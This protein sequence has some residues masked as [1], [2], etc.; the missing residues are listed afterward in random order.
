M[1]RRSQR[2]TALSMKPDTK[3]WNFLWNFPLRKNRRTFCE[4]STESSTETEPWNFLWNFHRKFHDLVSV[5]HSVEIPRKVP[6]FGLCGT[7]RGNSTESST[8][9]SQWKFHRK[10][11]R[12]VS[13]FLDTAPNTALVTPGNSS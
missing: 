10:F 13:G 11:Q 2:I 3:R 1:A 12:F 9:W 8:V 4:N 5:E 6:R 7:F